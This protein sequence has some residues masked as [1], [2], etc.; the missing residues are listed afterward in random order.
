MPRKH[1][2]ARERASQPDLVA[3]PLGVAPAW[4]QVDG[5]IVR[6]VSGEQGKTYRCPGC[7][8]EIRA[9]TPHLVVV[10][11]DDVEGR[12]H[13]HTACWRRELLRRGHAV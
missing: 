5:A 7:Q 9:A 11:R 4:A 8:Q 2:A 1:R 3:R 13:W 10:E 12:R 6:M